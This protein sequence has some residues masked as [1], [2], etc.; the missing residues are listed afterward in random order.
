M[1]AFR[2]NTTE[3]NVLPSVEKDAKKGFALLSHDL[4]ASLGGVL[5]S[6]EMLN[7]LALSA[8]AGAH[9]GR[10][11]ASGQ[12]LLELLDLAFD[13]GDDQVKT[14]GSDICVNV[15]HEL[16]VISD[17]WTPQ[18]SQGDRRFSIELPADMR[19]LES[20]DRV[21]FHRVLN[22]II[23]NA[24]KFSA[25]GSIAVSVT[26]TDDNS[27]SVA[28]K[29]TGP[30]F[31]DTALD[32]VFQFRS[33]P[34]NSDKPGSGLGLYIA[35]TLVKSMGGGI[36]ARN[37]SEGGACVTVTFPLSDHRFDQVAT[38]ENKPLPDL[39][40]LNILLAE[41]NITNQLVV[42]QMLKT[43]GATYVV[44]SDGVE[45]LERFETQDF[46]VVLLDIEMPRKSG[47]EVL[48]EIRNRTDIKSGIPLLA[49]TAY[50]LPEHRDRIERAG[51]DGIIPKPIEGI[52]ALGYSILEYMNGTV[53][54]QM[55]PNSVDAIVEQDDIGHIDMTIFN[56]LVSAIGADSIVD[57]WGKVTIDLNN[58]KD[59]L[60]DAEVSGDM[61]NMRAASHTLVSV[62]GAVGAV[63]LQA[64]A[65][66]LNTLAKSENPDGRQPLN[67]LC[68]KGI[69]EVL[70]FIKSQQSQDIPL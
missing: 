39:S 53:S 2:K 31:S 44:A 32:K 40:H 56:A 1:N 66:K 45:A 42:T 33:R 20:T 28:V 51:A 59:S 70:T 36:T 47:L 63:N 10:A 46:D 61:A 12:M 25:N 58:M 17:I 50:V 3:K 62:A 30:G 55:P 34:Q 7:T 65:G 4:R 21:S 18:F 69:L 9:I 35:S 26:L 49:L 64:S 60:I 23:S 29:D 22:N 13:M 5:G 41:D 24:N 37:R 68:I 8:E 16:K 27:V 67:M 48:R 52:A 43:M 57:F 54:G 19:P 11:R 38:P 14:Q 6:L 15:A